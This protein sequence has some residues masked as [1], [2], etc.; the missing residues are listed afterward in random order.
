M[1]NIYLDKYPGIQMFTF[2]ELHHADILF[3]NFIDI[4]VKNRNLSELKG[5]VDT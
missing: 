2:N 3:V 1:L 5:G 4:A